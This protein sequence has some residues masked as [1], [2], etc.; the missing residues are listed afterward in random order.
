MTQKGGSLC[1]AFVAETVETGNKNCW[2]IEA[3]RAEKS[4]AQAS[5]HPLSQAQ[6]GLFYVL[7]CWLCLFVKCTRCERLLLV[8]VCKAFLFVFLLLLFYLP[9]KITLDSE[10]PMLN[11]ERI[12]PSVGGG[13]NVLNVFKEASTFLIIVHS[14]CELILWPVLG[15]PSPGWIKTHLYSVISSYGYFFYMPR[16]FHLPS[17]YRTSFIP[18]FSQRTILLTY[19]SEQTCALKT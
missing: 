4:S 5:A 10:Q 8:E 11:E 17:R 19:A 12:I 18:V 15:L 14:S 9:L 13:I 16:L 7:T 1:Q 2:G 6:G 3:F